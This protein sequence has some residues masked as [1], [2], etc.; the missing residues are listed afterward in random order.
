MRRPR[1][2][3]NSF[4]KQ[5]EGMRLSGYEMKCGYEELKHLREHLVDNRNSIGPLEYDL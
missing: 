5:G 3:I 4:K 1:E 2:V